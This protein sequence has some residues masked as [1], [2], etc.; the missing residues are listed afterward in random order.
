VGDLLSSDGVRLFT[1]VD[2]VSAYNL[3]TGVRMWQS[4]RP[5]IG[6]PNVVTSAGRVFVS[7]SA[8]IALDAATGTELWR[9]Q[10]DTVSDAISAAD[11]RAYYIGSDTGVVYALDVRTGQPL[12]SAQAVARGTYR[13]DVTSI[14]PFED[15]LYVSVIQELSANGFLKRGWM[16][17]MDRFTGRVLWRYVNERANE[18]H[19]VGRQAVAGRMLLINDLN[20]GA[21]IG[22]D[23]F[24]GQEVWRR[25]GPSDR[26]GAADAFKVVDGI[27]YVASN[28]TY[29]YAVEAETGRIAWQTGLQAS[30]KS[31][32]VCGDKVFAGAYGL[33]MTNRSDGKVLATLFIDETGAVG[34]RFVQSRLLSHGNRVYFV[35][36]D[37]VYAVECG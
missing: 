28:D 19:D 36:S 20:G 10:P 24:T 6:P 26:L 7:S 31:S 1:L 32:A 13:T 21:M 34:S 12:W 3:A 29:L 4:P 16:V 18:P 5:P 17:A 14:L 37:G 27:G 33:H 11:N 8:A 23:R 25:V 2:G 9:F 30:A 15:V 22:V 35:G